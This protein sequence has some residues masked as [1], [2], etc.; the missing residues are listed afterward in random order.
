MN[1]KQ[2]ICICLGSGMEEKK[3]K[4]N[5]NGMNIKKKSTFFMIN[6]L[7][8]EVLTTFST[9]PKTDQNSYNMSNK[10]ST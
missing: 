1:H 6:T 5:R 7:C 4:Q 3:K 10:Y 2:N 8:Y 9:C